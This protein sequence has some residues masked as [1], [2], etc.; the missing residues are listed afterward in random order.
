MDSEK[1]EKT[2]K[3]PSCDESISAKAKRCTH[4]RQ[5]LRSWFRRHPILTF[6]GILFI[7][8]FVLAGMLGSSTQNKNGGSTTPA[9]KKQDTFAANVNFSGTQFI[10]NNFD[11][12]DCENAKMGVN[13]S[14]SLDG[15]LLEAGKQYT[16]GAAQ[17]AKGDGTRFNPFGV[18]PQNFD[19]YCRGN[20][21][22]TSVT[23]YGEFK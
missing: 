2:K 10:I 8:P 4:C 17:F 22:L 9:P 7:S 5:D 14:Y 21:E 11:K 6:L 13:G 18:K 1:E 23:W 3:C 12:Y 15:Y 20:N 19:I 16:V